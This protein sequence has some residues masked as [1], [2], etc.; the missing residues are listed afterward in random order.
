[1]TVSARPAEVAGA[2]AMVGL[3][4]NTVP[5]RARVTA[6]TTTAALLEELHNAYHHTFEH[7]HL[8]L[9][10]IHRVTGHEQLFDTLFVFENYPLDINA[11]SSVGGVAITE[12][13]SREFNHYALAVQAIP[14]DELGLRV[15]F[16]THV[17]DAIRIASLI[18][19]LQK[20]LGAMTTD[21]GRPLSSIDVLDT[22]ERARLDEWGNRPVL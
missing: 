10:E 21:P 3:L 20:V 22:D 4:I 15:E 17:F 13:S 12:F 7:Q 9:S 2:E 11:L 1:T 5:V 18:E 14:G 19:R 6:A 8:A 16:D